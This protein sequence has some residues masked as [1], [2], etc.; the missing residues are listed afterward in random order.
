MNQRNHLLRVLGLV[1]GFAAV[2]GSVVGQG[3]LRSP[4]IVA[5]AS[6]SE[7][8]IVAL[9]VGGALLALLAALPYAELGAALPSAGGV[10]AFAGRAFGPRARVATAFTLLLMQITALAAVAFV[11]GELMVRLGI[12]AGAI[13]PGALATG[14]IA[15]FFAVNALGTRANGGLQIAFSATKGVVLIALVVLLF[16]QPGAPVPARPMSLAPAGSMA[17]ATAMLVIIGAY[18]G[19]GDVVQY[20]EEIE[21]PA[22]NLPRALF[23]GIL[24][25]GALYVAVVVA[26]NHAMSVGEIA[27]SDFPASDAVAGVLGAKGDLAFTLFSL[28]SI[29]ALCSLQVMTVSRIAYASARDRI[30]PGWFEQVNTRGVPMRA[31]TLVCLVAATFVGSGTYLA[32][33]STST[34]LSQ[35][36]LLSVALSSI[37]LM[38]REPELARPYRIRFYW[39]VIFVVAGLDALLLAIFVMQDPF[40]A[41]LGFALVGV[42]SV[43]Y[44]FLARPKMAVQAEPR[45]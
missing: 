11:A 16:A 8:V 7:V 13:G 18:N 25:V 17:F 41:L 24:G 14:T 22:R 23:G 2:I 43:G 4:G 45:R 6:G 20:G 38:R 40:F 1:F 44:W 21:N 32:L 34:A 3:I 26:L 29:A 19:W 10:I 36:I 42:L 39:P 35:A 9:W 12:G 30:L 28:L 31:M 27:R 15:G 33:S 37:Q 5:Q